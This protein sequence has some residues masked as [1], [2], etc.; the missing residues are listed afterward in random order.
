MKTFYFIFILAL[1]SVV[2]AAPYTGSDITFTG[3]QYT[4]FSGW[5][6]G[7]TPGWSLVGTAM[8]SAWS[9]Q[10][11]EYTATLTSGNWNIGLNAINSG[12]LGTGWYSYFSVD[13]NGQTVNVTASDTEVFA[14]YINVNLSSTTTYVVR[15]TW[16]NDACDGVSRDAN[17]KIMDVF[18]DNTA[19]V[20][21]E[22]GGVPVPE[23]G[24]WLLMSAALLAL[25]YK[26]L[27]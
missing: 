8:C 14:G 12:Y 9:S 11:V 15:Y 18:F 27:R 16:L 1:L 23:P 26:R 20:P 7:S 2:Y 4:N 3:S 19:T 24:T 22:I 10:W 17:I 5:V 21:D 6:N 25:T 13:I